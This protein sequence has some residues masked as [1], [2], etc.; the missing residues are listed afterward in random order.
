MTTSFTKNL[1][2]PKPD[3]LSEPWSAQ[4]QATFDAIDTVLYGVS[5]SIGLT[6][7]LKATV[8]IPGNTRYDPVDGSVWFCL[9]GHTSGAGTFSA[10]RIAHPTFWTSVALALR[11]RGQWLQNTIYNAQDIVY[12]TT[13]GR[14]I[15]AICI[16]QHT[17]TGAGNINTDAANWT[18]IFNG[19]TIA[20]AGAISYDHT[21]SLLVAVTAQAAIDEL[22]VNMGARYVRFDAVQA[23]SAPQKTQA[24]A[25][26]GLGTA[27]VLDTG[28]AANKIVQ[29]TAAAKLP[30]VDGSLLTGILSSQV[31]G[32]RTKLTVNTTFYFRSD[33]SD[34]NSGLVNNAGGAFLTAQGAYNALVANYDFGG[35][36]VF[37]VNGN[38][39]AAGSVNLAA[40]WTGGG[41]LTIDGGVTGSFDTIA[42]WAVAVN[43][44]LPGPLTVRNVVIGTSGNG[45]GVY[46]NGAGTINIGAGVTFGPMAA[47]YGH[48]VS[49][50][51]GGK[52]IATQNY[53]HRIIQLVVVVAMSICG[54]RTVERFS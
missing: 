48:M 33:G 41:T 47:G 36:D 43:T 11:T 4:V 6:T 39:F 50:Y 29:M 9:V 17:S 13:G 30:A 21:T 51:Q 38:A 1:R 35:R 10:D 5:V 49:L 44:T 7:W 18:F 42:N 20:T 31:A 32:V 34:A 12:D 37:L 40:A 22:V 24:Q 27:S 26:L 16:T 19:A 14:S 54:V 25:N 46:C 3:F 53:T 2:F 52:I 45:G 23:L 8:Y 15:F 28:T